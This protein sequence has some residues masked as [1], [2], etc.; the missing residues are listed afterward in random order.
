MKQPLSSLLL[1]VLLT[2]AA[3]A[4]PVDF[5]LPTL[6]G[7][8]LKL[9]DYRGKW[10][11]VNFWASWC[12]P[13][14]QELP[15]LAAFQAANQGKVQVIG[16]NF[17]DTSNA[18]SMAF[19][20]Q[21]TPTGFPHAKFNTHGNGLDSTFFTTR[22]GQMLSLQGLPATF[23]IDPEGEMRGMHL[24]PLSQKT[25]AQELKSYQD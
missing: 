15:E 24:G 5:T 18:E 22:D 10:V 9:S 21:L 13:C 20:N 3:L 23:F 25:L 7:G 6:E 17:E 12:S 1:W 11:V 4:R 16:I 8:E 19:L 2:T 14:V